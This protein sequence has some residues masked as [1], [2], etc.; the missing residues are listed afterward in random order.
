MLSTVRALEDDMVAVLVHLVDNSSGVLKTE[1]LGERHRPSK[2]SLE[3]LMGGG[4][5]EVSTSLPHIPT[6]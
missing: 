3:E 6:I 2:Y 5:G 1:V 4:G